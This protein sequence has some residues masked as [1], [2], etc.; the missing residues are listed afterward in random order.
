MEGLY[1]DGWSEKNGTFD[2]W[3]S[4]GYTARNCIN[5]GCT[6]CCS[7]VKTSGFSKSALNGIYMFTGNL[8]NGRYLYVEQNQVYGIWFN[9]ETGDGAYWVLGWMSALA[10]GKVTNGWAMINEDTSCPSFSKVWKE[11][12]NSQFYY[13]QS[14]TLQCYSGN[15]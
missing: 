2:D 5:C 10:E 7:D 9:G 14:A 11:W 8:I 3:G 4:N 1:G 13:T 15:K 6:S 12:W